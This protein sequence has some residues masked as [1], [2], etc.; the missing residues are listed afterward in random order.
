MFEKK[1]LSKPLQSQ[2]SY[3]VPFYMTTN[4]LTR[5]SLYLLKLVNNGQDKEHVA[6]V[7]DNGVYMSYLP[8]L[9]FSWLLTIPVEEVNTIE[10]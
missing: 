8:L 9:A 7:S 10:R 4:K 2:I 5:I 6:S 3:R 1:T